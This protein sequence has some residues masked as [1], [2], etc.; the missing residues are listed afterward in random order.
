MGVMWC[1]CYSVHSL[2][3]LVTIHVLSAAKYGH[4]LSTAKYKYDNRIPA[5]SDI[6]P[7]S[8]RKEDDSLRKSHDLTRSRVRRRKYDTR[9][10]QQNSNPLVFIFSVILRSLS[11]LDGA[12]YDMCGRNVGRHKKNPIDTS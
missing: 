9:I 12:E 7:Q 11:L 6:N 10:T 4:H 3:I 1:Q 2:L 8:H 5:K